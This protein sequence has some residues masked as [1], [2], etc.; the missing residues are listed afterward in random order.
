MYIYVTCTYM[1]ENL[2]SEE[3]LAFDLTLNMFIEF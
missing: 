1:V 2:E 3:H